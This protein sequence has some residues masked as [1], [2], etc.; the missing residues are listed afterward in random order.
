MIFFDRQA[1]IAH[2]KQHRATHGLLILVFLALLGTVLGWQ[3]ADAAGLWYV[4]PSGTNTNDC[5]S[6]TTACRTIGGAVAK[7]ASGDTITIAAGTYIEQLTIMDTTLHLVGAGAAATIIDGMSATPGPE[8]ATNATLSLTGATL[9]NGDLGVYIDPSGIVTLN[10]VIV[11]NN[12]PYGGI[13]NQGRLFLSNAIVSGNRAWSESPYPYGHGG[14]GGLANLQNAK[15]SLTNVVISNNQAPYQGGGVMNS[16]T[17]TLTHVLLSTNVVTES[18][19]LGHGDADLGGGGVFNIGTLFF[20]DGQIAN[21]SAASYGGG[22]ANAGSATL[23]RITVNGNTA[24]FGAGVVNYASNAGS[25]SVAKLTLLNMT[26]SGNSA[27]QGGGGFG[28]SFG[29]ANLTNVTIADNSAS[30]GSGIYSIGS[31]NTD[32][33]TRLRNT[34]VAN[35]RTGSNCG[36][37]PNHEP[38]LI[39]SLGHNLDSTSTC[40]LTGVGDLSNVDPQ[41]TPLV[42]T[43]G[44]GPTQA[45]LAT[46]PA[47]DSGDSAGCPA[48]DQRGVA[49]PLDG[50]GDGLARCDIGAYERT[51]ES[52]ISFLPEVR[53]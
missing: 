41:L 36:V 52:S 34:I 24:P 49:R 18:Y 37:D 38:Q 23:D 7:A 26:I 28:N 12:A 35:N 40:K 4:A 46:S 22:L 43:G 30:V 48:T 44:F 15:A 1:V 33:V 21:N 53:K 50:D 6:S 42:A 29:R 14:G 16:G 11:R 10:D 25:T 19:A 51:P 47:I 2:A 27:V 5:R 39:V 9:R 31:M 13:L 17:L 20:A 45:L 32:T 3:N 8:L